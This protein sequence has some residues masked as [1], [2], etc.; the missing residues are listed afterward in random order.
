MD[1]AAAE[2]EA[3][4][5]SQT[6]QES[7]ADPEVQ[8]NA[9]DESDDDYVPERTITKA[10]LMAALKTILWCR[11]KSDLA[12]ITDP[13]VELHNALT[14]AED[15][16]RCLRYQV[17]YDDSVS[18]AFEEEQCART[19]PQHGDPLLRVLQRNLETVCDPDLRARLTATIQ[20][21]KRKR[22]S[23]DHCEL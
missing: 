7:E 5:G 1:Q 4:A 10:E 23:G 21:V 18:K 20:G 9:Q 3:E 16:I 15:I 12:G 14:E 2:E 13:D 19:V 6:E 17:S 22:Y 11:S 8:P